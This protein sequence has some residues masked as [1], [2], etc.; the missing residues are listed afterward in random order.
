MLSLCFVE[1]FCLLGFGRSQHVASATYGSGPNDETVLDLDV[2]GDML[3]AEGAPS[4][5]R[6]VEFSSL[7][8]SVS[9]VKVVHGP[10]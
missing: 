6:S 10:R 3:G 1:C 7:T 9:L 5:F 8:D 4:Y 2:F